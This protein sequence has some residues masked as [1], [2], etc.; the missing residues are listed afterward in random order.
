MLCVW[1]VRWIC[2]VRWGRKRTPRKNTRR[3]AKKRNQSSVG[4]R[5]TLAMRSTIS[6]QG[7]EWHKRGFDSSYSSSLRLRKRIKEKKRNGITLAALDRETERAMRDIYWTGGEKGEPPESKKCVFH[8]SRGEWDDL[9][10]YICW[11]RRKNT[12]RRIGC[13]YKVDGV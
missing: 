9:N 8:R 12:E 11:K 6:R 1:Q 3:M 5:N 10:R 7:N 13:L 4:E 2:W